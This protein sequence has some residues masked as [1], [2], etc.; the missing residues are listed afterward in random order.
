MTP[1]HDAP[2]APGAGAYAARHLD[3]DLQ[4]LVSL[5]E[6]AIMPA[7]TPTADS[8]SEPMRRGLA[9]TVAHASDAEETAARFERAGSGREAIAAL[10]KKP[11]VMLMAARD[12][13]AVAAQSPGAV[14]HSGVDALLA[15]GASPTQVVTVAQ[16]VG[17]ASFVVQL[18]AVADVLDLPDVPPHPDD[19]LVTIELDLEA[20]RADLYTAPWT[21]RLSPEMALTSDDPRWWPGVMEILNLYPEV[22]KALMDLHWVLFQRTASTDDLERLAAFAVS[23]VLRN[24]PSLCAQASSMLNFE[25]TSEATQALV[26]EGPHA[27][28]DP[29]QRAVI[30]LG[31]ALGDH[32]SELPVQEVGLLRARGLSDEKIARIALAAAISGWMT[33]LIAT[34][35]GPATPVSPSSSSSAA[36]PGSPTSRF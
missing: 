18:G 11:T 15:A 34:L 29:L 7:N 30:R 16:V 3:P 32:N 1:H 35:G 12:F 20:T 8:I 21:S 19:D 28:P 23:W 4:H 24:Q 33:R 6:Q 2:Q 10:V 17:Y 9:A 27:V 31:V 14:G 13:A 26:L 5:A 25:T 22:A 36:S